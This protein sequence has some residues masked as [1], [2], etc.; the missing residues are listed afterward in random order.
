MIEASLQQVNIWIIVSCLLSLDRRLHFFS[1]QNVTN[2]VTIL[3]LWLPILVSAV[4][5]F[6]A[7]SVIHMVLKYHNTDFSKLPDEDGVREA[8]GGFSIPP[9]DYIVPHAGSME[10]M[11]SEEFKAK[12]EKG[13]NA[14]MTVMPNGQQ[15]MTGSLVQWFIFSIVISI[16]AAYIGGR[17]LGPGADYLDVFR[18]VGATAF[19]GYTAAAWPA[20]IWYKRPWS[21]TIKNTIDGFIYA[22][23]TAGAFGWLWPM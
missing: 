13:P 1:P 15:S 8:L 17:A 10:A 9:G 14:M 19:I 16:F 7:S 4:F 23:L 2:M 11:R 21:T 20:S 22:L 5:V 3:S 6:I 18:F 12:A